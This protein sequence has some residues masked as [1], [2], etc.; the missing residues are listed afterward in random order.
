MCHRHPVHPPARCYPL[1][2][3][4]PAPYTKASRATFRIRSKAH[5]RHEPPLVRSD[6][7][8]SLH[9]AGR[10]ARLAFLAVSRLEKTKV[11]S[12]PRQ[13]PSVDVF[14][15]RLRVVPVRCP[16]QLAGQECGQRAHPR[17]LEKPDRRHVAD[18]H[19]RVGRAAC[20]GNRLSWLPLACPGVHYLGSTPVLRNGIIQRH[21]HGGDDQHSAHRHSLWPHARTAARLFLGARRCAHAGRRCFYCCP[22]LDRH[23]CGELPSPPGLQFHACF[24]FHHRHQGL[25]AHAYRAL[26]REWIDSSSFA[27]LV[28]IGFGEDIERMYVAKPIEWTEQGVLM[29]DQRRL[30]GEEVSYT[31]TDYREVAKGIREMIIR[32]APAI[33]VAAPMGPAPDALHSFAE[34][35]EALRTEFIEICG[36]LAKTRPTAVDLF[37]ALERMT[38]RSAELISGSSHL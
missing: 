20:G 9:Y 30:P 18:G 13:R 8:F 36:T 19:G 28:T 31:Y 16:C 23:S 5:Y 11:R 3:S 32:G 27:G 12:Q 14:P 15:F 7:I 29:L 35:V 25:H 34:S 37:W 21:P 17:I 1:Y 6:P 4:G 38:R 33:G 24:H 26:N 22:R 10:P 2:F